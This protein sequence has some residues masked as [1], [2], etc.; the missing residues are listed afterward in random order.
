MTLQKA[1][2]TRLLLVLEPRSG[3]KVGQEVSKY[4][5]PNTFLTAIL[6]SDGMIIRTR[7][8]RLA[9]LA[10]F[11]ALAWG[12][13]CFFLLSTQTGERGLIA[14]R[15]AKIKMDEISLKIAEMKSE[16]VAWE[17]RVSQLSGAKVDRDLL[18]E[19]QRA[20]LN[21]AHK[22]DVIILLSK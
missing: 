13:V 8:R 1:G 20:M 2:E 9:F 17:R 11:H 16:R 7:P 14:K 4:P 10:G 6:D 18:D 5:V 15:E 12:L 21:V 3:S 22:N 19:R